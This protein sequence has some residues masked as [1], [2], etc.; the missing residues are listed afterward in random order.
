MKNITR[1]AFLN[2]AGVALLSPMLLFA[3]EDGKKGNLIK[4]VDKNY[5][6]DVLADNLK[7]P[8]SVAV[9]PVDGRVFFA[10]KNGNGSAESVFEL[11]DGKIEYRFP[12]AGDP[13]GAVQ[14]TK[15]AINSRNEIFVYSRTYINSDIAVFDLKTG[16]EIVK[17]K[18]PFFVPSK[19]NGKGYDNF[20]ENVVVNPLDDNF[21]MSRCYT[22]E[23][24]VKFLDVASKSIGSRKFSGVPSLRNELCFDSKGVLYFEDFRSLSDRSL[25]K[26][27][28]G[29]K[30]EKVSPDGLEEI[31]GSPDVCNIEGMGYDCS[32]NR[33]VISGSSYQSA[34]RQFVSIDLNS[35]KVS[36]IANMK[37]ESNNIT[38]FAVD[39]KGYIYFSTTSYKYPVKE[40]NGKVVRIGKSL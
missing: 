12:G 28:K 3:T 11:V 39:K 7:H 22:D 37:K 25:R 5:K 38:G 2:S 19:E 16:E 14:S 1:R 31:I 34:I 24:L 4:I 15:L 30:N 35:E 17:I 33:L 26:I 29:G 27:D 32:V 23:S 13:W 21:Y 8:E 10:Q 9:S 20:V 36:L 18:N 40:D 6:F